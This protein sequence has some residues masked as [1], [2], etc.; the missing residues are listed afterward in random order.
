MSLY[1]NAFRSSEKLTKLDVYVYE[2]KVNLDPTEVYGISKALV[3]TL[4]VYGFPAGMR[5]SKIYCV[6]ARSNV[7][8]K[9]IWTIAKK[10]FVRSKNL[11]TI[12]VKDY[13]SVFEEI[14]NNTFKRHARFS[15]FEI[16]KS[17]KLHS[18]IPEKT[19]FFDEYEAIT[20]TVD[21]YSDGDVHVWIDPTKALGMPFVKYID[22]LKTKKFS[23]NQIKEKIK[24]MKI[25]CPNV[26]RCR[27]TSAFVVDY[28]FEKIKEHTI[29][30]EGKFTN[31]YDYWTSQVQHRN[32]LKFKKKELHQDEEGIVTIKFND[33]YDPITFPM[34]L[35]D[36]MI[37]ISDSTFSNSS[38]S[39]KSNYTESQRVEKTKNIAQRILG[40][41]LKL[42]NKWLKFDMHL[43]DWEKSEIGEPV[44]LEVPE[45]KFGDD[46][47]LK[48]NKFGKLNILNSLKA[49]GPITN[50]DKINCAVICPEDFKNKASE[51]VENLSYVSE[52][53]NLGKLNFYRVDGVKYTNPR[54][55]S[56]ACSLLEDFKDSIDI[57][58]VV[59]PKNGTNECYFSAKR[60]LGEIDLSSQMIK[61]GHFWSLSAYFNKQ[62]ERKLSSASNVVCGI[63]DKT[64]NPGEA[65]WQLNK[66]AGNLSE[67]KTI[68][69]MGFDVS[70]NIEKN[71]ES[72]AY[73]AIC[74]PFGR[75]LH[76]KHLGSHRGEKINPEVLADWFFKVA[77]QSYKESEKKKPL[78]TLILF[79]DG[80]IPD[81]QIQDY[82]K[83][84][85]IAK[86]N[87]LQHGLI[88]DKGNIVILE[89]VKRG[90]QRLFGDEKWRFRI[91]NRAVIRNEK[92]ALIVTYGNTY[93]KTPKP[94]R[95]SIV[96]QLE[97][98]F[99]I[100]DIIQMFNHLRYLDY[101]SIYAQPKTILPLHIVQNQA[102]LNKED[103]N[104]PYVAR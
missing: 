63:F 88:S 35:C 48:P 15:N 80:N 23:E 25:Y 41:G 64:L 49:H 78:D 45:L 11:I 94:L 73:A 7:K 40:K 10:D 27:N 3:R 38:D 47:I 83:A 103:I 14:L 98:E 66:P 61:Y 95:L 77:I 44:E 67:D 53:L 36:M 70:R 9:E 13:R 57:V 22:N 82:Q 102:L 99:T 56:L 55:Y 39:Y 72:G 24:G 86:D 31:I 6:D 59:L 91:S 16:E 42:G 79:K 85:E 34:S 28:N 100:R 90:P 101:S 12:D 76:R 20:Y 69:F 21:V 5:G 51:L 32:Y 71:T 29:P 4:S 50:K 1:S 58:L 104:V 87:M 96:S 75:I 19:D 92:E 68:Y 52:S 8:P 60:S 62:D 18:S 33:N 89:V 26:S 2:P 65:M 74:D 93:G 84:S 43:L 81:N 46:Y 97:N 30:F 37:D 54:G 17:P